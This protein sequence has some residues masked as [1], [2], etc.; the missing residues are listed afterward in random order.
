MFFIVKVI[1]A[2]ILISAVS[3]LAGKKVGLAGFLTAI[4]LTSLIALAF[5]QFEWANSEQSIAYAKSILIAIP[6]STLF[7]IPFLL[8]NK[9]SL[10]FWACYL[11]GV[12]LLAIGYLI[13]SYILNIL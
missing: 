7:F 3:W 2:A 8:A 9:F 10:S 11:I 13:H 6:I 4:P 5:T 1:C 12:V